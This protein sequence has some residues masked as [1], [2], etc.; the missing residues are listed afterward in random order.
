MTNDMSAKAPLPAGSP[1]REL[2][3]DGDQIV[4]VLLEGEG[5]AVPVRLICQAL[6]LDVVSQ[7]ERIQAHDVLARGLRVVRG[8]EG[9][10]IAHYSA[11]RSERIH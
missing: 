4:A 5:T 2:Q 7:S 1:Y 11:E 10:C 6:G 3:F 9:E 8:R